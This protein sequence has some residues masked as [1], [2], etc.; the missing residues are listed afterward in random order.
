M[1]ASGCAVRAALCTLC[2]VSLFD[3]ICCLLVASPLLASMRALQSCAPTAA[4]AGAEREAARPRRLPPAPPHPTPPPI[5]AH[6]PQVVDTV[7]QFL[8]NHSAADLPVYFQA[9]LRGM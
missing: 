5:A 7:Q 8:A 1:I 9:R 3:F 2:C 6:P 4:S